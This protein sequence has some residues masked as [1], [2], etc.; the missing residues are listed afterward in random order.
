MVRRRGTVMG[1]RGSRAWSDRR[2]FPR[3]PRMGHPKDR[4]VLQEQVRV[5]ARS[6]DPSPEREL[7]TGAQGERTASEAPGLEVVR[8]DEVGSATVATDGGHSRHLAGGNRWGRRKNS[9]GGASS[10]AGTVKAGFPR[11]FQVSRSP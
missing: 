1:R 8:P 7:A 11:K 3:T 10:T 2:E 4:R 5:T 6:A 9:Y